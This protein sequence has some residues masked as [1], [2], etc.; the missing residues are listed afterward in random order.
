MDWIMRGVSSCRISGRMLCVNC[1][2][3][4][5]LPLQNSRHGFCCRSKNYIRLHSD[6]SKWKK[7]SKFVGTE[8]AASRPQTKLN[9]QPGSD[10]PLACVCADLPDL[11]SDRCPTSSK[12]KTSTSPTASSLCSSTLR[13]RR[14]GQQPRDYWSQRRWQDDSAEAA[15]GHAQPTR[16]TIRI[17]GLSPRRPSRAAMS[18]AICRRRYSPRRPIFP[19]PCANSC[20]LAWPARPA[21]STRM[22]AKTLNSSNGC[23]GRVGADRPGRPARGL[24]LRRPTAEGADRPVPGAARQ[25]AAAR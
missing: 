6:P 10:R 9:H 21:C 13:S 11:Q 4:R 24:D 3:I 8:I 23:I 16:G 18:S 17:V 1:I 15:A 14:A 19:S 22:P 20:A 2:A 12:S 25:T 5:Y 7:R